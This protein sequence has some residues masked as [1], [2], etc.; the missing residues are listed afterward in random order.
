MA[1][2][3]SALKSPKCPVAF[4]QFARH[5]SLIRWGAI[6]HKNTVTWLAKWKDSINGEDKC[7]WLAANSS[8]KGKSDLAKYEKARE[9]KKHIKQ[10][11]TDYTEGMKSKER[12][13]QQRSVAVY[14]IDRLALRVG[15]E[16]DTGE[17]ADTVGCCSLRVEHVKLDAGENML[18]LNFLGKDSI[19]YDN[20]NEIKPEVYSLILKFMQGKNPDQ[21]LFDRVQPSDLNEYFHS[22]MDGLSAKV[23]RTYNASI[24]LCSELQKTDQ[25]VTPEQRRRET[26]VVALCNYYTIA[27]KTVAILCNHQKAASA[28]H[29]EQM[30]K[31]DTQIE[32][33]K[34]EL[35]DAKKAKLPKA[36]NL[37]KRLDK[38]E[39]ARRTKDET[40]C[41]SL[42]T[43]KINYND[44]RITIAWCK[45][46]EV[47]I[48]K[49][50][51]KTLLAKFAWAMNVEPSFRF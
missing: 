37:Q 35:K 43:S 33:M 16:K 47:P 2:S 50:F 45:A 19:E 15:G 28:N 32:A 9:L 7:V 46:H 12:D 51:P 13:A 48:Q 11:R 49:Q 3:T 22:V 1:R 23:F 36:E 27:N 38:A 17:E 26:D 44:P 14:L 42:G 8:W 39:A 21:Q 40:K 30:A 6:E 18:H 31:M 34:A 4:I 5:P 20:T 25:M 41:V 29:T 24:T 10:V